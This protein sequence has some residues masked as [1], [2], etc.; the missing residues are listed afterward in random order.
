MQ[1]LSKFTVL[2]VLSVPTIASAEI[3]D[4]IVKYGA[5]VSVGGGLVQF[6]DSATRDYATEGAGWEGRI[7][8]GTKKI[9][10]VEAGYLGSLHAI[11]AL[12][13]DSNA[14]L[15]GT[16]VEGALRINLLTGKL[17]P[18]LLAGAGWGHYNL[19]NNSTNTSDV[20]N[21]DNIA[22]FPFGVGVGYKQGNMLFDA[23]AVYRTTSNVDMFADNASALNSWSAT[24]R[25]GFEY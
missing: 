24:L 9:L 7:A 14:N 15:L 10:S 5:S 19:T 6:T 16:N 17:Q 3:N 20:A 23:R 8:F 12:G 13:L 18:F 2:A 22:E 25:L 11:D 21:S 4:T 1:T